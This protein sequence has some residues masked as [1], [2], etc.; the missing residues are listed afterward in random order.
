MTAYFSLL[1][2][3]NL[4]HCSHHYKEQFFIKWEGGIFTVSGIQGITTVLKTFRSF[5][6]RALANI[7]NL[8]DIETHFAFQKVTTQF[9]RQRMQLQCMN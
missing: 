7:L 1:N 6:L 5:T 3:R 9:T 8:A 4:L 2:T